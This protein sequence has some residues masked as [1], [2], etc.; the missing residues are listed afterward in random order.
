M[1]FDQLNKHSLI[2]L[3]KAFIDITLLTKLVKINIRF[4]NTLN[5]KVALDNFI[6]LAMKQKEKQNEL[7]YVF[8][9]GQK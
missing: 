5:R 4:I 2:V 8:A 9:F 1:T 6:E 7:N 3:Q